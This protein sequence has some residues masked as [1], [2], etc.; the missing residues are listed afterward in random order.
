MKEILNQILNSDQQSH[1]CL[2]ANVL[3]SVSGRII[4]VNDEIVVLE[5]A[6]NNNG[7][8][9]WTTVIRISDIIA[10]DFRSDPR[11]LTNIECEDMGVPIEEEEI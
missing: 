7:D 4:S 8:R 9:Y 3:G 2:W 10:I 11:P 6:L 5:P 1:T